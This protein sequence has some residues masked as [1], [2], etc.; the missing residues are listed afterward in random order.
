[1]GNLAF[2]GVVNPIDHIEHGRLSSTVRTNNRQNLARV[3]TETN[4][5]E[6][7]DRTKRER[8]IL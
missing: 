4:V 3:D 5:G 2:A 1:V 8:D 6:R 7:M